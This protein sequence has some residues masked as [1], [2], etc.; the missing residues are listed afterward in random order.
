MHLKEG[1]GL[2]TPITC[3]CSNFSAFS[4]SSS[5]R[6]E[7]T[8]PCRSEASVFR[9][10]HPSK[11]F[12]TRS[13]AENQKV[14]QRLKTLARTG[15]L[16]CKLKSE[17]I[18]GNSSKTRPSAGRY[19]ADAETDPEPQ[20]Y[21]SHPPLAADG[22]LRVHCCIRFVIV[23]LHVLEWRQYMCI[24]LYLGIRALYL[25]NLDTHVIY[26]RHLL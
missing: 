14:K 8:A 10:L 20:G 3:V 7:K 2:W 4:S 13:M 25:H 24:I 16:E 19:G 1:A 15:D 12:L 11:D 26:S 5:D 21:N 17:C 23:T 22:P 18:I 6:T 9:R